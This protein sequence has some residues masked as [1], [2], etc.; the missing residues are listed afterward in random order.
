MTQV[1]KGHAGNTAV[2]SYVGGNIEH[3]LLAV[4]LRENSNQQ[5]L[6]L[7]TLLFAL[8]V[9]A[10]VAHAICLRIIAHT[11]HTNAYAMSTHA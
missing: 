7:S 9:T 4:L 6:L 11:Y 8:N 2:T 5:E 3:G 1:E 10:V